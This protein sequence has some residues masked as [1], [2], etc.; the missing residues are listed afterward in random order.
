MGAKAVTG[1][2]DSVNDAT[3]QQTQRLIGTHH[4]QVKVGFDLEELQSMVEHGQML[5]GVHDRDLKFVRAL[6]Q[7][8][9]NEG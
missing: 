8:V 2:L 1:V 3:R 9:Y 4:I 6:T 5:T 7:F